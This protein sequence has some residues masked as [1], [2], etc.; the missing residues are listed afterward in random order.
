MWVASST[1]KREVQEAMVEKGISRAA[2]S[3]MV[4][5]SDA[6][7]T[8]LFKASTK[9]SRLVPAINRALGLTPPTQSSGEHDEMLAELHAVWDDLDLDARK[10]IL[11][12]A[13]VARRS[14]R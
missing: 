1:W 4:H 12:M 10:A 9:Q 3:R 6:A 2:L 7:I 5:V 11:V 13:G 8:I 14:R